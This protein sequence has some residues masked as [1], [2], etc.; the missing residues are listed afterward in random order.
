LI[1][2]NIDDFETHFIK[3]TDEKDYTEELSKDIENYLEG[4]KNFK[5]NRLSKFSLLIKNLNENQEE[6][7]SIVNIN[8][9]YSSSISQRD[10]YSNI[11]SDDNSKN[12]T[13][14]NNQFI[15]KKRYISNINYNDCQ[16]LNIKSENEYSS[17]PFEF[18]QIYYNKI[19]DRPAELVV[20]KENNKTCDFC[21]ESSKDISKLK[22]LG[23][24]YGPIKERDR[25]YYYVHERCA[26][27]TTSIYADENDGKL[28][29][30]HNEVISANHKKCSICG[31]DGAGIKC[32]ENKCKETYHFLCAH[33]KDYILD[34]EKYVSYCTKHSSRRTY[35]VDH[36]S[37]NCS[38]CY[39]KMD[40]DLM[41]NCKNCSKFYHVYCVEPKI[42]EL[43][44]DW[45]CCV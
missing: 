42:P 31:E 30:V 7:D 38:H 9:I 10:E 36:D 19:M 32:K 24:L 28:K 26:L 29:N 14:T 3:L 27:F 11:L 8:R 15:K 16:I 17:D 4:Y 22:I 5:K 13:S 1:K 21:G 43:S 25:N 37:P 12:N 34:V 45:R 40:P 33:E 2:K 6:N 44:N 18:V 23:P 39:S 41:V 20:R 35:N